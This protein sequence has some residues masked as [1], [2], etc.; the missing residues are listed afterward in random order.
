MPFLVFADGLPILLTDKEKM[1]AVAGESHD[2]FLKFCDPKRMSKN[3]VQLAQ[4]EVQALWSRYCNPRVI[5]SSSIRECLV[6][7]R[8]SCAKNYTMPLRPNSA[9]IWTIGLRYSRRSL[10]LYRKIMLKC[11]HFRFLSYEHVLNILVRAD[12]LV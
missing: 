11:R 5:Q 3:K 8:W 7:V 6:Q 2:G 4:Y 10:L 12:I 1:I 9:H